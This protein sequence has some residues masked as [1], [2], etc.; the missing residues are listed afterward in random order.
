MVPPPQ[1]VP[2]DAID[3]LHPD[4][5]WDWDIERGYEYMS[6]GFWRAMGYDPGD[7]EHDPREWRRLI[8]PADL[9]LSDEQ[10]RRHVITRGQHEYVLEAR[11]PHA[12]GSIVYVICRGRVV[13]WGSNG[14][15]LRMLGTHTDI[16]ALKRAMSDAEN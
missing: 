10:F 1:G 13:R 6:P 12:D 15:P 5:Y 11:Y 14:E 3:A 4:G 2:P 7:K 8:H 16:T 9:T